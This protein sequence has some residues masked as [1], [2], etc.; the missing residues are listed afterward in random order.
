MKKYRFLFIFLMSIII[1]SCGKEETDLV[2]V[3]TGKVEETGNGDIKLSGRVQ[4]GRDAVVTEHGFILTEVNHDKEFAKYDTIYLG[5]SLESNSFE[6]TLKNELTTGLAYRYAAFVNMENLT[7]VG[8]SFD[9]ISNQQFSFQVDSVA[10]YTNVHS[11]D[12]VSI[13]G[14][15]FPSEKSFWDVCL[16]DIVLKPFYQSKSLI[17]FV[18]PADGD[19]SQLIFNSNFNKIETK[20]YFNSGQDT[21]SF[22]RIDSLSTY[23]AVPGDEIAIYGIKFYSPDVFLTRYKDYMILGSIQVIPSSFTEKI[24]YFNLPDDIEADRV[25]VSVMS[26]KELYTHDKEI[27]L[28][29]NIN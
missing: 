15:G 2:V 20:I 28:L 17:Q 25:K 4:L 3:F 14:S 6:I 13:Y 26:N 7:I 5:E 16:D 19:G 11:D 12:T 29:Q 21:I 10:Q 18:F 27:K 9:F 1:S 23:L 8:E 24:I 22:P